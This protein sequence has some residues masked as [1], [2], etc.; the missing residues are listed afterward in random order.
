MPAPATGAVPASLAMDAS[1][2]Y[3]AVPRQV[4]EAILAWRDSA[5]E[6]G[7]TRF[8]AWLSPPD[9][10]HVWVEITSTRDGVNARLAASDDSVQAILEAHAPELRET[11]SDAGITLT[12]FDLAEGSGNDSGG[13]S[14]ADDGRALERDETAGPKAGTRG[15]PRGVINIRA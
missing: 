13:E 8:A 6:H 9:L 7:Q 5:A 11:L 2:Q 10:G 4:S 1:E 3:Q 15:G 14:P 12:G